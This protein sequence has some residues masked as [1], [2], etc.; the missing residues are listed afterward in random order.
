[1]AWEEKRQT[2][3]YADSLVQLDN[4]LK[5]S[6][7]R[8]TCV[9]VSILCVNMY[10]HVCMYNA[11]MY[12]PQSRDNDNEDIHTYTYTCPVGSSLIWGHVDAVVYS[13][14]YMHVCAPTWPCAD[15]TCIHTYAYMF[16]RLSYT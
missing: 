15:H 2:S 16:V 12:V 4:G 5:I 1:M 14:M 6:P 11:C 9:S 8:K 10:M 13:D 3:K 7:D